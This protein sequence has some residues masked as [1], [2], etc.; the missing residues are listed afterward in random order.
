MS[1]VTVNPEILRWAR[2]TARLGPEEAVKKIGLAK[3]K[4]STAVERLA[5]LE[6]GEVAPSRPMLVKMAKQYRRPLLTFYLS[7]VPE[8]GDRGN[9]YRTLPDG[10][11]PTDDVFLD[12][13]IRG[14][15]ARQSMLRAALEDEEEAE[16]LPFIGSMSMDDGQATVLASIRETIPLELDDFRAAANPDDAFK[17]LRTAV[18]NIGIYVVLAGNLGSYHTAIDLRTFRGFALSDRIAP[19]VVMNDQDARAA[20]SFTLLHE[21]T[22]LW[23]GQT[24]ISG[25]HAELAVEQFCNDIAGEFLL[26]NVELQQIAL[27]GRANIG[28][29]MESITIFA[30]ER[31]VSRSMVAYKLYRHRLL[32]RDD[33]LAIS[34]QFR[35][36]WLAGRENRRERTRNQDG[37][38][39]YYT[40]RKHRLGDALVGVVERMMSAGVLTTTKAGTVLG[41]KAKNVQSLISLNDPSRAA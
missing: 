5:L 32:T 30:N 28:A 35:E 1:T 19:F 9:D 16:E 25:G 27:P 22:H 41:V 39:D 36:E 12:A 23:L 2:E 7:G 15:R 8:K 20:W 6:S 14:I 40:V 4:D 24:G 3:T 17:L 29:V 37:G 21:I 11:D 33:W 18:E 31:N 13:L 10:Y 26:P 38:V 34:R